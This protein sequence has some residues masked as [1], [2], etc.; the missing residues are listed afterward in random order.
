MRGPLTDEQCDDV[1]KSV[2]EMFEECGIDSYPIDP[3]LIAERLC[4]VLRRYSDLSF[5]KQVEAFD[6]SDD[7]YSTVEFNDET[8]MYQY[9]IYYNDIGRS[10]R[11]IRWSLFHEIGHCYRGHHDNPDDSQHVIEEAEA[12]MFA[13]YAIAP[14]PLIHV[15][16]LTCSDDVARIF[17]TTDDAAYNSYCYYRKWV[18]YGPME[19]T[20]FEIQLLRLFKIAA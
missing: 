19:Y 2:I 10:E 14:P 8:G 6:I 11:R 13:K 3:Y 7:S 5:E 4:Y 1:K 18:Q 17:V 20:D 12:N 15:L 9:V 16:K